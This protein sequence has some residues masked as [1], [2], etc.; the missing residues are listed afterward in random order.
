[1]FYKTSNGLYVQNAILTDIAKEKSCK[2]LQSTSKEKGHG[3]DGYIDGIAYSIKYETYKD[4]IMQG[5]ETIDAIMV[6]NRYK[7]ENSSNTK[8]EKVEYYFAEVEE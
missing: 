8:I 5:I 2:Y 7:Y 6:Y 1:M 3:I 4:S